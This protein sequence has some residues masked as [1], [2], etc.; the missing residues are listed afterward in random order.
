M[1]IQNEASYRY[2]H[3]GIPD[4]DFDKYKDMDNPFGNSEGLSV[5]AMREIM[6]QMPVTFPYDQ[7][8]VASVAISNQTITARDHAELNLRIYR[9]KD[10]GKDAV[11][12][13]VTHGG[14]WILGDHDTEEAMN[15]LV[16]K[17]TNSV[18]VSVNYRL[19]PEYPFPY[20][21]NDS[22]DALQWCREN[23]AD[24]GIDPQRVVV[25]GSS[26]GGN[27]AAALALK[28][29][30]E[31]IGAVFGQVL[32]FPG[33]C[34]PDHFPRDKYEYYSPE[35]NKDGPIIT[36][37]A[38]HWFWSLYYPEAGDNPYASPL[39][40]D[41]HKDLA[42]ASGRDPDR[43][44][45][46]AYSEALKKAGVPVKTKVYSGLPHAFNLFPDLEETPTF[47]N[48]VVNWINYLDKDMA[49]ITKFDK[50]S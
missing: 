17:K 50:R 43:D 3:Y 42:P 25:G 18:V 1:T 2:A 31:G 47:Y 45:A 26:S 21:V 6:A 28:D 37:E 44:E 11:L 5:P 27:I 9:D 15:R 40:A 23:A 35:Q 14:G 7:R 46:L 30:D 48:T 16:A 19:A 34:H 13:F 29:R 24:L 10:V 38:V 33:T 4:P 8:D 49:K 12:F 39:L 36:T 22:F 41:S 20:A 32:N